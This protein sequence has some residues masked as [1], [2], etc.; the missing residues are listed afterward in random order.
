MSH[1]HGHTS[2]G[3]SKTYM[4][5]ASMKAR[6]NNSSS[7]DY[8]YYGGRG[9]TIDPTWHTFERFLED[10]GEAPAGLTLER[11]D[12][13][14]GYSKDNCC[15]STWTEQ[16]MNKRR[17]KRPSDNKSGLTGV[18]FRYT[19]HGVITA[20]LAYAREDKQTV[21]LYYGGDFF[22]AC[23]RRKSWEARQ[24]REALGDAYDQNTRSYERYRGM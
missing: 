1:S 9:I 6:C 13:N 2:G 12:N 17:Q 21:H 10:M 23:C 22:E 14:L 8:K 3:A 15:W 7:K 24:H 19:S 5:W 20:I 11:K 16:G 18:G 4:V